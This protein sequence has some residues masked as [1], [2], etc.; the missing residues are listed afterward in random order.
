LTLATTGVISGTPTAAG[1]FTFSVRAVDALQ[2][3]VTR[4]LTIVVTDAL[5]ITS[6]TALPAASVGAPYAQ[7]LTAGGGTTPYTWE[8]TLGILPPGLTLTPTTGQIAGT[9]TTPGS[10]SFIVQVTDGAGATSS[11]GL[12]I[13]VTTGI[14]IVTPAALPP[15]TAR[16]DYTLTFEAAGGAAPYV[17]EVAPGGALPLGLTLARNGQ[18]SGTPASS[19]TFSFVVQVTDSAGAATTRSFTLTVQQNLTISTQSLPDAV[20]GVSYAQSLQV[21]GGVQPYSWSVVSGDVPP[22][23]TVSPG[24]VLSGIPSRPGTFSFTVRVLDSAGSSVTATLQINVGLPSNPTASIVG[25]A[26]TVEPA[27]QPRLTFSLGSSYPL[28]I[29]GRMTMTFSPDASV[30][31]KDGNLHRPRRRFASRVAGILRVADGNGG[32][33]DHHHSDA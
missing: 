3:S 10:Y 32:G 18:L 24:G 4:S 22:G 30:R 16:A 7:A 13:N 26:E 23:L 29:T 12:T 33:H 31:R 27:Q 6:A 15:A 25:L 11:K 21:A 14:T 19:G 28:P 8:L 20:A 9:A 5:T 2:N 17:W 1:T